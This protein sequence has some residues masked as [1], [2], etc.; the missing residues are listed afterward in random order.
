M[1]MSWLHQACLRAHASATTTG[2]SKAAEGR[3][4]ASGLPWCSQTA[5]RRTTPTARTV[6]DE[7]DRNRLLKGG[8]VP[9]RRGSAI[10]RHPSAALAST[11]AALAALAAMLVAPSARAAASGA[12]RGV[13][14]NRCLDVLGADQANGTQLQTHGRW[15]GSNQQWTLTDDNQLTVY[16]DKCLDV[17]DHATEAGTRVRIWTCSGGANQQWRVNSDG[18]IVGVQSGLCLEAAGAGTANGTA[19]QIWTCNGGGNQK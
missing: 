11:V 7:A 14:S 19:V 12:L 8:K 3:E 2:L 10:R 4:A 9:M 13:A 15:S 6:S 16:G 18:T 1:R 17:P 5:P